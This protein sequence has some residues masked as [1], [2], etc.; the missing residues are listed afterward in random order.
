MMCSSITHNFFDWLLLCEGTYA[1]SSTSTKHELMKQA[2]EIY[3]RMSGL[4]PTLGLHK[5]SQEE[6][7]DT[8]DEVSSLYWRSHAIIFECWFNFVVTL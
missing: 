7:T 2:L 6:H 8:F 1:H 5:I 4:N 3:L